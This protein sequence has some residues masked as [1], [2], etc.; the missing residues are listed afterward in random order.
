[1][2]H[3]SFASGLLLF[4]CSIRVLK[5]T[6]YEFLCGKKSDTAKSLKNSSEDSFLHNKYSCSTINPE[7]RM[8][9]HYNKNRSFH[10]FCKLKLFFLSQCVVPEK[11]VNTQCYLIS[12]STQQQTGGNWS[13]RTNAA[14]MNQKETIVMLRSKDPVSK[15]RINAK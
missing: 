6:S 14:L 10:I 7:Y 1:M 4:Q 5:S 8:L 3:C 15:C 9:T 11:N 12:Y 13:L 2:L